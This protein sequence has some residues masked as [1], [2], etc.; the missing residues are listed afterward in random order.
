MKI[1]KSFSKVFIIVLTLSM[2][3]CQNA[4][5]DEKFSVTALYDVADAEV[6]LYYVGS[7]STSGD[8][9]FSDDFSLYNISLENKNSA[10]TLYLYALRDGIQPIVNGTIDDSKSYTFSNLDEGVYLISGKDVIKD[11]IKY[12]V[13]PSIVYVAENMTVYVKN[14]E[15]TDNGT[16][17][18]S[19]I[20]IWEDKDYEVNRPNSIDVQLL[21]NGKVADIVT[22]NKDN[23]WQYSWK[24]LDTAYSWDVVEKNV[25]AGYEVSI[26]SNSNSFTIIN[27]YNDE[28]SKL[29]PIKP[30]LPDDK[31]PQTGQL[32]L[33]VPVL[34][35]IGLSSIIIGG[36]LYKTGN[37]Y[38]K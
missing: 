29:P 18:V 3:V 37:A 12:S 8:I 30:S 4:Y 17:D 26:E 19:V 33:P 24:N 23:Q 34:I 2:L 25:P 21:K 15:E 7:I 20:K 22:L 35:I 1:V 16:K 14:S 38:E 31:L 13:V 9:I 32:W 11:N 27:S 10:Y 36:L 28:K 6:A 5:A